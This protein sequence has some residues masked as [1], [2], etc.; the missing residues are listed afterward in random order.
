MRN[1][2]QKLKLLLTLCIFLWGALVLSPSLIADLT[3]P[4]QDSKA[5]IVSVE[6]AFGGLG[7]ISVRIYVKGKLT[8]GEKHTYESYKAWFTDPKDAEKAATITLSPSPESGKTVNIEYYYDANKQT[9]N[10][11]WNALLRLN[12]KDGGVPKSSTDSKKF[13]VPAT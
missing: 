10:G 9:Q 7:G 4:P 2:I 6:D 8:V 3:P 11:Q 5:E 1:Q 13:T 12:Y